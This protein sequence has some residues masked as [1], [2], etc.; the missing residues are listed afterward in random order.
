MTKSDSV[1]SIERRDAAIVD[2]FAAGETIGELAVDFELNE[3]TVEDV[4]RAALV[5]PAEASERHDA[6]PALLAEAADAITR[7]AHLRQTAID[8]GLYNV[9]GHA[10]ATQRRV[11]AAIILG[12]VDATL[13]K[14][15]HE[16]SGSAA[17]LTAS[18]RAEVAATRETLVE[19]GE[20]IAR[21]M[22]SVAWRA[23]AH[24]NGRNGRDLYEQPVE[25]VLAR[26][27]PPPSPAVDE[28]MLQDVALAVL[29]D[30]ALCEAHYRE[31][32]VPG[33][34]AQR[35]REERDR[36]LAAHIERITRS[37]T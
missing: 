16:A 32:S 4:I 25:M 6:G 33:T 5:E 27:G 29:C 13:S 19:W 2:R 23:S 28:G 9:S 37:G 26:I 3:T 34:A 8:C 24:F 1:G 17:P 7:L 18:P 22:W 21:E 31:S 20:R 35:A 10:N 11:T 14:R 12:A 30:R 15:L 36:L